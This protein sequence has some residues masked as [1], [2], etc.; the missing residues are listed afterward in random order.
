M[1]I[2]AY[3]QVQMANL[4]VSQSYSVNAVSQ[5]HGKILTDGLFHDLLAVEPR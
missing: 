4:C 5:L 2:L 3:G 1:A